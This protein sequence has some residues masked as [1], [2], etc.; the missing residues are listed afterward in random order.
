MEVEDE[1]WQDEPADN[2][3]ETSAVAFMP[4]FG[5][6][7]A[8]P[9]RSFCTFDMFELV[10]GVW[11]DDV[12]AVGTVL[13]N[14]GAARDVLFSNCLRLYGESRS[15]SCADEDLLDL[16]SRNI[17]TSQLDAKANDINGAARYVISVVY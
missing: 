12:K 13:D 1:R 3:R 8:L 16:R 10:R 15:C 11:K 14:I 17:E 4:C 6:E 2:L 5:R 7:L 9:V